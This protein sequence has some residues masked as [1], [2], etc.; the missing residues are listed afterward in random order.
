M[1]RNNIA[2]YVQNWCFHTTQASAKEHSS[3]WLK[4]TWKPA[5]NIMLCARCA[6]VVS[7]IT[8]RM[9]KVTL[10]V[11]FNVDIHSMLKWNVFYGIL[12]WFDAYSPS[13][14]A[15]KKAITMYE[16][17]ND[18]RK[19]FSEENKKKEE[20]KQRWRSRQ[21]WRWWWNA[22]MP[23]V[24]LCERTP[25]EVTLYFMPHSR[26]T[27]SFVRLIKAINLSNS[28]QRLKAFRLCC[29]CSCW[30]AGCVYAFLFS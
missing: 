14:L 16:S 19:K 27:F 5:A 24:C 22:S 28:L 1:T 18:K 6:R 25:N 8:T 15:W 11:A 13:S 10:A 21:R 4:S 7:R 9:M 20:T 26:R 3:K 17:W 29:C 30:H 2:V 23:G 12:F